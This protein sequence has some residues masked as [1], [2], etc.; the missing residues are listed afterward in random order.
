[1]TSPDAGRKGTR[2][3]TILLVLAGLA[4]VL[5]AAA[6]WVGVRAVLLK[7]ELESLVPLAADLQNAMAARDVDR[8]SELF[9]EVDAHAAT[10]AGLSGDPVWTAA[11]VVPCIGANLAAARIVS[12]QLHSIAAAAAPLVGTL[13]QT[14]SSAGAGFDIELLSQLGGPVA[15]TADALSAARAAFAELDT[16]QLVPQLGSGVQ[17]L[18]AAVDLGAA[19]VEP[20][21]PAV[22]ALPWI[23]GAHGERNILV[24]LQNSAELR[25]G[26]GITGSFALL[27]ADD[28]AITLVD[29][30]DSGE[31]PGL[32]S[33]IRPLPA[34]TK[35][36]YGDRVARFVQNTSMLSDF[37]STAELAT[38]WWATRSDV[39]PDAVV[40]LDVPTIAALLAVSGPVQLPSGA[41]LTTDNLIQ[42]MLTDV[43]LSLDREQQTAFQ[44]ELT[45]TLFSTVFSR[46]LDTLALV[47]SLTP[48]IEEG[49]ISMWS[50]DPDVEAL[51]SDS[52]FAGQRAR[53]LAAGPGAF[54]VYLNDATS[55]KMGTFLGVS[56][57]AG[58]A[59]CRV[60]G[61]TD[62]VV[63]ATL[64]NNAPSDA[65]GALPWWV[66]GGGI[67]GVPPGDIATNL[68]VA[69]PAGA[70]FGGVSVGADR[71]QSADIEDE[72]FPTS[73]AEVTLRP[74]E[75]KAV[76]F[77]FVVDL[78]EDVAPTILHTPLAYSPT[79]DVVSPGCG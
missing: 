52:A 11:E 45:A 75:S 13:Q 46:H 42:R 18:A 5:V 54:A 10:A 4:V 34:S 73:S 6:A 65:G 29:Q 38:A 69:A 58:R 72:G 59:Q 27:H 33:P 15:E 57:S 23:L 78:P 76:D 17:R 9:G 64:T 12:V 67:E 32:T 8:V 25:T 43:Y 49:R 36:L 68:S 31:F 30:A 61:M 51:L 79:V 50:S 77:R 70:Y 26:G 60:D 1:M 40:S 19:S 48:S 44:Q 66:T 63:T 56:L 71:L 14:D 62:V 35:A 28:G 7:A 37:S 3:R 21:A 16:R 24:M 74:G 20:I 55:G 53:Q 22:Q 47:D 39:V 2:R 41:E